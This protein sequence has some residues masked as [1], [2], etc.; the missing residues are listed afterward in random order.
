MSTTPANS[1]VDTVDVSRAIDPR[2][3]ILYLAWVFL[4]VS[5]LVHPLILSL[6][7]ILTVA[8]VFASRLS[9]WTLLKVGRLGWIVAGI[10]WLLW[11]VFLRHQGR[12]LISIGSW[13]VTEAGVFNGLSVAARIASILLAFLVVFK[14]TSTRSVMTAL[15]RLHVSVP[16][17][18]VMGIT[19]RLIPQM[20]SEHASILEAQRSRAVEFA[21]G[22]LLARMR[23]HIAYI[24][25]LVL[26]A[27]KITSDLSLAM[28]ARA[29]D[30]Y[31]QRTFSQTLEFNALDVTLLALMVITLA[32]G[33]S[34]RLLGF[35]GMPVQWLANAGG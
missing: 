17:A 30:P 5:V 9:L 10:S 3:K 16:F 31:A 12:A 21:K 1:G 15:Y 23:K 25:P 8:I 24:I 11:I 34:A 7:F 29:F 2:V 26:R 28:E 35:G 4:M 6:I 18:M 20:Q 33:V 27:L 14:T 32:A 19:L 22:N 13:G